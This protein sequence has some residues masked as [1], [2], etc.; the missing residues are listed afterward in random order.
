MLSSGKA[1]KSCAL[2]DDLTSLNAVTG[3][4]AHLNGCREYSVWVE[5]FHTAV[6]HILQSGLNITAVKLLAVYDEGYRLAHVYKLFVKVYAQ[7]ASLRL[8]VRTVELHFDTPSLVFLNGGVFHI[9]DVH[10]NDIVL[11]R[12]FILGALLRWL[13]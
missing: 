4:I 13:H 11:N 8:L 7:F 9:V 2:P 10:R 12:H 6:N 1:L 5:V 3:L